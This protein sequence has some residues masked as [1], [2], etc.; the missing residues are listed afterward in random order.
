VVIFGDDTRVSVLRN[1]IFSNVGEGI[2]LPLTSPN[3]N[4]DADTGP[5]GGQNFPVITSAKTSSKATTI[6]G[7]L[8]SK[9]N[10][11]YTLM[12]FSNLGDSPDGPFDREGKTF[13]VQKNDV[14]TDSAGHADFSVKLKKGK[15][16]KGQYVTATATASNGDTSE[17]SVAKKVGG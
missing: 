1:S 8:D 2:S 10:Q 17:F 12:F 6:K 7:T 14:F 5:N 11:I 4:L 13:K 16:P 15:I 9:P 3:D